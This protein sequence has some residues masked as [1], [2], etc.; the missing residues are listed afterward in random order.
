MAIASALPKNLETLIEEFSKL[1]GVGPKTAQRFTFFLLRKQQPE[2]L[3]L[4]EAIA[5]MTDGLKLCGECGHFAEGD[6]C[7]ICSNPRRDEHIICTVEDSLDLISIE[8]SGAFRGK[9]HIL[10]GLISPLQGIGPNELRLKE[11]QARIESEPQKITEVII[12]TNPTLEGEATATFLWQML[13]PHGIKVS[14][15]ARGMPMGGDLEFTDEVT[16]A[17]AIESRA[18]I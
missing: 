15:I 5:Q 4:S 9:Y 6:L 11:L 12:A 1:P 10:G 7:N 14:R 17:K 18:D 2:R 8:K 3:K 13:R 16:L